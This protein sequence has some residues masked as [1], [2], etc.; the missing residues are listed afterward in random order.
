MCCPQAEPV[1]GVP[2]IDEEIVGE[3][4][5]LGFDREQLLDGLRS[6]QANKATVTYYLMSDNRWGWRRGWGWEVR[7]RGWEISSAK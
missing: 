2:R 5:R 7:A 6:R 1:V 4:V 3:V